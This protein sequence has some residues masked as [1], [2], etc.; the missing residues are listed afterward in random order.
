MITFEEVKQYI[1][2]HNVWPNQLYN[3]EIMKNDNTFGKIYK[4][5]STLE[6]TSKD[7]ETKLNKSVEDNATIKKD[8]EKIGAKTR[9][10]KLYPEGATDKQKEFL[11][12]RF[13]P[14]KIEDLSDDGLKQF[15]TTGLEEFK[16][17]AGIFGDKQTTPPNT[18]PPTPPTE[19]EESQTD[20]N[21]V[22]NDIMKDD[23]S[24]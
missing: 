24:E 2:D 12:K 6:T 18:P 19:E 5:L 23:T 8:A 3:E 16:E 11:A 4:D 15:V 20:V 9:L 10:E 17:F 1:K 14:D 21:A 7:F 13:N 22:V